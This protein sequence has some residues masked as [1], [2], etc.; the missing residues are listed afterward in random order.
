MA[1][2][3]PVQIATQMAS[4]YVQKSR[5]AHAQQSQDAKARG[6]GLN[7]LSKSLQD[8]KSALAALSGK[9]SLLASSASVS[10]ADVASVSS[11]GRAQPGSYTLFVERVAS[12]HQLSAAV[13]AG[14]AADKGGVVTV[15]LASGES[16]AVNLMNADRDGDLKLSAEELAQAINQAPDNA[17]KVG[18]MVVNADGQPRLL[19][20]S[21]KTGAA[22]AITLDASAVG[23]DALRAA[24][25]APSQISRAEDA[26]LWLGEQ[27]SGVKVQQASN[28]F[29]GIDGVT[30]NLTRAQKAGDAPLRLTVARNDSDTAANVQSFVDAYN[31]LYKTLSALSASGSR[32]KNQAAGAFANDSGVRALMDRLGDMAR[33]AHGGVRLAEL[34]VRTSRDGTLTLD[35]SRLEKTLADRPQALDAAFGGDAGL[36]KEMSGYLDKWLNGSSGLIKLRRDGVQ[37]AQGEL[38]VRQKQIDA[39]YDAAYQR[40]LA[41]YTRLQTLQ[42]QMQQTMDTLNNAF[43]G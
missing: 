15:R 20:S 28:T 8:F 37:R 19:L 21:A 13:P 31:A 35:K 9:K 42:T 17:G 6:D 22:G 16:F 40:Y 24:L 1:E 30:L 4:I 43:K 10:L 12:A 7:Q 41:Q 34:G 36:V 33:Q 25:A 11:S 18:A 39:Q 3:N 32:E 27:G 29:T 26:V 5:Q 23:D 2:I 14:V 38:D